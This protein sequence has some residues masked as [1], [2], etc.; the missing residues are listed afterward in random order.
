MH[1]KH[2]RG[3]SYYFDGSGALRS[4]ALAR[5]TKTQYRPR[6]RARIV[7]FAA[8]GMA[9]ALISVLRTYH[10]IGERLPDDEAEDFETALIAQSI[11]CFWPQTVRMVVD[12]W[13][14][15]RPLS[16]FC[17][18]QISWP[19]KYVLG[20]QTQIEDRWHPF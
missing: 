1:D 5:S 2:P 8:G 9:T 15:E 17:Q 11:E 10:R 16:C 19:P 14:E 4:G 3:D 20:F 12:E 13:I 6:Q 7:L 18:L